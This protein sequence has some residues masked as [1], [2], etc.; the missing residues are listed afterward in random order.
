MTDDNAKK[1]GTAGEISGPVFLPL[2]PRPAA[3]AGNETHASDS[4]SR[5]GDAKEKDRR[6]PTGDKLRFAPSR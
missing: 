5:E 2:R 6:R 3:A 4:P 1:D